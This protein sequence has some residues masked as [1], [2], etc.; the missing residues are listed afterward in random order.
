MSRFPFVFSGQSGPAISRP[1]VGGSDRRLNNSIGVGGGAGVSGLPATGPVVTDESESIANLIVSGIRAA[2]G[3]NRRV[4]VQREELNRARRARA[5]NQ[6]RQRLV[7]LQNQID[8]GEFELDPERELAD[9]AAE[10]LA[11]L[12]TGDPEVDRVFDS[13]VPDFTRTL[14]RFGAQRAESAAEGIIASA[15]RAAITTLDPDVF[16]EQV[17]E[18]ADR[19]G[20]S[21]EVTRQNLAN[22]RIRQAIQDGN[23]DLLD[24]VEAV[25]PGNEDI[26]AARR[27]I[28]GR[29]ADQR[30]QR[31]ETAFEEIT[32]ETINLALSGR[33]DAAD[34]R[35]VAEGLPI[36]SSSR[37]R[38]L[39][40]AEQMESARRSGIATD[41][42][43]AQTRFAVERY[44]EGN[45]FDT[46]TSFVDRQLESGQISPIQAYEQQE[47]ILAARTDRDNADTVTNY[48]NMV[49]NRAAQALLDPTDSIDAL[50][51]GTVEIPQ[52]NPDGSPA[53]PVVLSQNEIFEIG[54]NRVIE[55]QFG[56]VDPFEAYMAGEDVDPR[57][58]VDLVGRMGRIPD[59]Q[60]AV[61]GSAARQIQSDDP[62]AVP[63][64]SL[65][66]LN[67][68]QQSVKT[69][70]YRLLANASDDATDM[71]AAEQMVRIGGVSPRQ[72][73][74]RTFGAREYRR[75]GG[76]RSTTVKIDPNDLNGPIEDSRQALDQFQALADY[77]A[78][79][80]GMD[81]KTA[82]KAAAETVNQNFA[83]V[84]TRAGRVTFDMVD[85]ETRPQTAGR[86]V[87]LGVEFIRESLGYRDGIT[88]RVLPGSN[89]ITFTDDTGLNPIGVRLTGPEIN[90]LVEYEGRVRRGKAQAA[91]RPGFDLDEYLAIPEGVRPQFRSMLERLRDTAKPFT[92]DEIN[93][94]AQPFGPDRS[95]D[96][97]GGRFEP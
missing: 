52:V 32:T 28:E 58:W 83:S 37:S 66:V 29:I 10:Q 1:R 62:D 65:R 47:R 14:G 75:T 30:N 26:A 21:E 3:V 39:R 50:S 51:L 41:T 94:R 25:D 48:R 93:R 88:A 63:E 23:P 35:D 59:Q 85:L 24:V 67:L 55:E 97:G 90:A 15:Q 54:Y 43:L 38:L 82:A 71:A 89:A 27:E 74:A 9:I 87:D 2:Q 64:T 80:L 44:I 96:I 12:R 95:M 78:N 53:D 6:G 19:S 72:A 76:A 4:E 45:Q 46:A 34:V 13:L 36:E 8:A 5:E 40:Q 16:R 61:I 84:R 68:I 56:G 33:L 57:S 92:E 22:A 42:P 17:T 79:A 31:T 18:I 86:A 49:A 91:Q 81:D 70:A 69:P 77:N 73:L 11:P 20:A 60:K 7:E